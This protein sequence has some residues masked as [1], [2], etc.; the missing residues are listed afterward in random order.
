[1][2]VKIGALGGSK[3]VD[4]GG[5]SLYLI[6]DKIFELRVDF[7]P[8]LPWPWLSGVALRAPSTP[9]AS[10][11]FN[12]SFF[13]RCSRGGGLLLRELVESGLRGDDTAGMCCSS[14]R[15]PRGRF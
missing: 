7:F 10:R 4:F 15:P 5:G 9:L 2:G 12:D 6:G 3:S 13:S 1:M 11:F 8:F 14:S